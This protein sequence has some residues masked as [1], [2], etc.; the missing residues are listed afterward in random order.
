MVGLM[1][2]CLGEKVNIFNV[3]IRGLMPNLIKKSLTVSSDLGSPEVALRLPCCY[4]Y[5]AFRLTG[6]YAKDAS[7]MPGSCPEVTF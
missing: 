7:R 3:R 1:I 6:G 4:S 2:T 5:A